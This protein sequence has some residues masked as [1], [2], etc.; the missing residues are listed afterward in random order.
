MP[1]SVKIKSRASEVPDS[2]IA[3]RVLSRKSSFL[4]N[5][6]NNSRL[7]PRRLRIFTV[8]LQTISKVTGLLGESK[9]SRRRIGKSGFSGSAGS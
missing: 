3:S 9:D 5:E 2:V 1:V 6:T 8:L 4:T 7:E